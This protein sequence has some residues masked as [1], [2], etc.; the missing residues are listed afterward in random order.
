[1]PSGPHLASAPVRV[2]HHRPWL[3]LHNKVGPTATPVI[4]SAI[5]IEGN[6]ATLQ[7]TAGVFSPV[8]ANSRLFAVVQIMDSGGFAGIGNLS[9]RNVY[10]KNFRVKAAMAAMGAE[11]V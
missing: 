2:A 4:F 9:L 7:S 5:E 8:L 10:I 6:G 1:M 3:D 11:A